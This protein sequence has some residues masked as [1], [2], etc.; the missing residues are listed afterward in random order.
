LNDSSDRAAKDAERAE[1]EFESLLLYLRRHRGFDFSGYKRPSLMRR[2]SKRMQM[3]GAASFADYVDFLEVHPEEFPQLFNSVLINVTSFFRDPYA[4]EFLSSQVLPKILEGKSADEPVRAW[5]AGCASGEEA[6][7]IAIVLAEALGLEAFRERVK[8]YATDVDEEA[9][10]LARQGS[11]SAKELEPIEPKLRKKY[12]ETQS[13]RFVFRPDLRR[14][15][16]F[17]R[18]D[19]V[20]D[21]PIS[22][23]DLVVCRNTMMYFNAETQARI[24]ARFHFAL[25]GDGAGDSAGYLYLGRA[26][27]LLG[28]GTLFSPLDLKCRIFA[29]TPQGDLRNRM[30]AMANHTR[31]NAG[32]ADSLRP[33][34]AERLKD[35][36]LE[37]SPAP[38]LIVDTDGVLVHANQKVRTLFSLGVEDIGRPF[39]DL[40]LSYRPVELRSLIEQAYTEQRAVT[41]SSVERRFSTGEVQYLDVVVA[42]LVAEAA[43]AVGVGITFVDVTHYVKLQQELLHSK[44]EIQTANEELQSAN[45]ELETTNEELQS[46]NEELETTNE[47]LQS[48]NEELETMNEEL[49][50]TNEELQTVNSELRDRTD[51]VNRANAFLESVFASLRTGAVVIDGNLSVE[52]WNDRAAD[53]WGLRAD[54]VLGKSLLNLDIG[55]PIQQMRDAIR[56]CVAGT[57]QFEEAVLDA[58][59]RRGKKIQCRVSVRTLAGRGGQNHGAMLLM[60]EVES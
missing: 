49:Q 4:W 28:H 9:L 35:L 43:G 39:K 20:Q 54:E 12:F 11:Y 50:S 52:V 2:V 17:G 37:E 14:S 21:A 59:N 18:H 56:A 51:E 19:L 38:R 15:V 30:L 36:A 29:R 42:P 10:A 23:L 27:M 26:E 55:L 8:I 16:I 34:Y 45:E 3:V 41:Q 1:R 6:Y 13:S 57:S 53:L 46:A 31:P 22:R 5:S 44:D 25:N 48:T 32:F 60:D 58:T 47:E 33:G 24:L 40:E 7:S